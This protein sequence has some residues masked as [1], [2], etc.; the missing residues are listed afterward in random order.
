MTNNTCFFKCLNVRSFGRAVAAAATA[1]LLGLT[2]GACTSPGPAS[3]SSAEPVAPQSTEAVAEVSQSADTAVSGHVDVDPATGKPL[4]PNRDRSYEPPREVEGMND[5]SAAGASRFAEYFIY[6]TDYA[7]NTGDP[8]LIGAVSTEDCEWCQETIRQITDVKNADG[9]VENLQSQV[10]QSG[11]AV[12]AT[13]EPGTWGVQLHVRTE[14]TKIFTGSELHDVPSRD[15]L[16]D[17][18]LRRDGDTW[19]VIKAGWPNGQ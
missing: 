1:T 4:N 6:V 12:E 13:D 16:F 15:A 18:V 14:P 7:W 17:V 10:L 3:Q 19:K 11:D 9:W 8:A 5:N 2:L